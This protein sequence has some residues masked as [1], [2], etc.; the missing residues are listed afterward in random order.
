MLMLYFFPSGF[1][2]S[3]IFIA[4]GGGYYYNNYT[5][6]ESLYVANETNISLV[7]KCFRLRLFEEWENESNYLLP[8][9]P[10]AVRSQEI[11]IARKYEQFTYLLGF[12]WG[13]AGKT[14]GLASYGE[15]LIDFS[16]FKL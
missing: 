5:E 2:N 10:S 16:I 15:S 12:G 13:Q 7:K 8:Y 3:L 6:A 11:S 9:M 1:P 4:D 14:M